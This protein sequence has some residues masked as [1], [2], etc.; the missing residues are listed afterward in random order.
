MVAVNQLGEGAVG[1]R[2]RHVANLH[3]TIEPQIAD[4][5]E[6]TD[7]EPRTSRHLRE[8]R[9][10]AVGEPR[11]HG[12]AEKRR[13]GSDF[14]V[15]LCADASERF[16]ERQRVEIAAA[17]VEQVANHRSQAFAAGRIRGGTA[18]NQDEHADQ[19]HCPVL[20]RP[21]PE[22]RVERSATD[23]GKLVRRQLAERRQR[24]T[25]GVL[26]ET[27]TGVEPAS[28]SSGRPAG[29]TLRMTRVSRVSHRL[30]ARVRPSASAARYLARSRSK[31]P[32][33]LRNT[34]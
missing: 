25:I 20:D 5:F 31:N 33:S 17:F 8:E 21:D 6:V 22:T 1:E 23:L 10:A 15:E 18:T 12:Q 24:R 19:R 14:G 29:T 30:A 9:R 7:V 13:V 26:H 11:Q 34:L 4:A 2:R 16:V 32:G 28:A 27:D 3:E